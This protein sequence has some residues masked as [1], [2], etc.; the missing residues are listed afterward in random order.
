MQMHLSLVRLSERY[1]NNA[2][3][4]NNLAVLP[5][6][7]NYLGMVP[8]ISS[9][10]GFAGFGLCLFVRENRPSQ[11][12][13]GGRFS[14]FVTVGER[15]W[16][17]SV[18]P[19]GAGSSSG[20]SAVELRPGAKGRRCFDCGAALLLGRDVRRSWMGSLVVPC[21]RLPTRYSFYF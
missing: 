5:L 19:Y 12:R 17:L 13:A 6:T 9:L 3:W 18:N 16:G 4:D 7:E 20:S 21:C 10:T 8:A 2:G 1:W 15:Q 11:R 14:A